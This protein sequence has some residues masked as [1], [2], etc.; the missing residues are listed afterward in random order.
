[1]ILQNVPDMN[2]NPHPHVEG[3]DFRRSQERRL[4]IS[5]H[6]LTWRVTFF[7]VYR[8]IAVPY[9]NPHPHVEGDLQDF[10]E[11]PGCNDFNPHPHV[12]GD[13]CHGSCLPSFY[14]FNPH[15]HVEGNQWSNSQR[16]THTGI[17]IHT[18]TWRVTH[19][20]SLLRRDRRNF[21]PHPHVEG[22]RIGKSLSTVYN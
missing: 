15:P 21:N 8:L 1:M 5:I 7:R 9:F 2:F 4:D 22:D 17:S 11:I 3:D 16:R 20:D 6:T 18:L 13:S 12:E 14:N 19:I 10:K